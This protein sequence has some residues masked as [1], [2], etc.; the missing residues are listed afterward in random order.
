[1]PVALAVTGPAVSGPALLL[2]LADLVSMT[3]DAFA[4]LSGPDAVAG[5]T[6]AELT[7]ASSVARRCTAA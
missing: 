5:W 1:M 6:G 2:G 3:N 4:Y 7:P